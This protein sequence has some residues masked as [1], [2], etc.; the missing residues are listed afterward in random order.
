[1]REA[2]FSSIARRNVALVVNTVRHMDSCA[3]QARSWT[4]GASCGRAGVTR[5][6]QGCTCVECVA[7]AE[8][9][10]AFWA[11]EAAHAYHNVLQL[12]G[13]SAS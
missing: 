4:R 12:L 7:R 6:A 8:T 10:A 5:T 13:G 9:Y 11:R 3:E 1:M 2:L